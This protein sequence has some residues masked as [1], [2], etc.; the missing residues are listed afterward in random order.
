MTH[1]V[2]TGESKGGYHVHLE[3]SLCPFFYVE[4]VGR[5]KA[6]HVLSEGVA[7]CVSFIPINNEY[8]GILVGEPPYQPSACDRA[9]VW[10]QLLF[11]GV[12]IG[13]NPG[14]PFSVLLLAEEN[15]A[16]L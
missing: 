1:S 12:M 7:E 14:C 11:A 2:W 4:C 10:R 16:R 13:G 5:A 9:D 8:F 15:I 6:V 3:E